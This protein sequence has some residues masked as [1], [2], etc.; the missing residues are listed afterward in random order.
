MA[1][2]NALPLDLLY[3][4]LATGGLVRRLLEL[5]RDE[6]LGIGAAAGDIT[7]AVCIPS[8]QRSRALL[9]AREAGIVAGLAALPDILRAFG[10]ECELAIKADD[11]E[12]VSAGSA[13]AFIR[14]QR[15]D[16]LTLERLALNLI[17]RLSGIATLTAQYVQEA[18]AAG[19]RARIFD[20]RKTTPGLRM[21]E[22]YAVRCGGGYAH[23]I[24]L[25]DAVL[26]KDNHLA[27]V[28]LPHFADFVSQAAARARRERPDLL[29]V[30]VEVD[31][32]AQ[33]E[34][35][36]SLPEGL[37]DIILLDNMSPRELRAAAERRARL[38]PGLQLEASGGIR[39]D[40][41]REIAATG[42]D[43]ISIGALTHS[44]VALDVALDIEEGTSREA[45]P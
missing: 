34:R 13:L 23:R 12:R 35:I 40:T 36:V 16:I 25:Y 6:D 38:A 8:D 24:G 3:R 32:L 14:G 26:I 9:I 20:T 19:P 42:V 17:G 31:S 22:K 29:F 11:G 33:F 21:L 5:A 18:R 37:I 15:R 27:G 41:V 43:R 1:D 10:S 39:L 44:A 28:D 2:L 4:E 45:A 7:S 30:E